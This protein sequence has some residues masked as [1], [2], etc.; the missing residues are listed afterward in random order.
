M[1]DKSSSAGYKDSNNNN[2]KRREKKHSPT[3]VKKR[4]D[5]FRFLHETVNV[6]IKYVLHYIIYR[7]IYYVNIFVVNKY[8]NITNKAQYYLLCIYA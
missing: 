1:R 8:S 7:V 5:N 4:F 6:C 3:G 2:N